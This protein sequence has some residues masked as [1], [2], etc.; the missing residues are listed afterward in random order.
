MEVTE[1]QKKRLA[2]YLKEICAIWTE[3]LKQ[4]DEDLPLLDIAIG[5]NYINAFAKTDGNNKYLYSQTFIGE[6][7]CAQVDITDIKED[8]SE[9][10]TYGQ[11]QHWLAKGC[12]AWKLKGI[13]NGKICTHITVC[14][15]EIYDKV[16]S[17]IV[18]QYF[19][20]DEWIKPT[21]NQ[22]MRGILNNCIYIKE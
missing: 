4:D 2:F 21:Y 5:R 11:L 8:T 6:N 16:N 18:I 1:N 7:E 14:T 19:G 22:Y 12:G 13:K 3:V 9:L 15:A 17:D 20:T 10:M